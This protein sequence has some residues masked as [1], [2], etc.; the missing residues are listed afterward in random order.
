[1]TPS[2]Y[3]VPH[4]QEWM[5]LSL[6]MV[7]TNSGQCWKSPSLSMDKRWSYW[8]AVTVDDPDKQKSHLVLDEPITVVSI[9]WFEPTSQ[10]SLVHP[11]SPDVPLLSPSP[12]R[13]RTMSPRPC[14][15]LF[16]LDYS[17]SKPRLIVGCHDPTVNVVMLDLTSLIKD[18][19]DWLFGLKNVEFG[20]YY[21]MSNFRAIFF[22]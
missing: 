12:C 20:I 19:L 1:M 16:Y 22:S 11:L 9:P 10:C 5:G 4:A 13:S 14:I 15:R 17:L 3:V 18:C 7:P 21:L 2:P 8:W 6:S